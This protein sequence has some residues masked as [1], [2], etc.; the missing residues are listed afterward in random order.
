LITERSDII[1][2]SLEII[3]REIESELDL[4]NNRWRYQINIAE[5]SRKHMTL[6]LINLK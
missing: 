1:K 4:K 2:E 6:L 5:D 3:V